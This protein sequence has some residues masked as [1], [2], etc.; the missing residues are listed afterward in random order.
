MK[1]RL[2]NVGAAMAGILTCF[3]VLGALE[4]LLPSFFVEFAPPN[5]ADTPALTNF[6]AKVP[7]AAMLAL[8]VC[9][10]VAGF[11]GGYVVTAL[12]TKPAPKRGIW[13]LVAL[14]T[15][16]GAANFYTIP[17]PIW[18]VMLSMGVMFFSPQLGYFLR[19]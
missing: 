12:S 11:F 19:K 18:V 15:L 5:P 1:A 14:Y 4:G 9:Y 17:H 7:I 13:V 8:V 2:R 10:L 3:M 16:A 6:M